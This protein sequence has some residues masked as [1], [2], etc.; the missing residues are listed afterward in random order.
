MLVLHM[1]HA[2]QAHDE[3]ISTVSL[4]E[5]TLW[6]G[7]AFHLEDMGATPALREGQEA[8]CEACPGSWVGS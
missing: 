5:A 8:A 1:R 3:Y 2:Q 4:L 7:G 6:A